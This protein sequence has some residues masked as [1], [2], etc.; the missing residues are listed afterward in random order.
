MNNQTIPLDTLFEKIEL[1]HLRGY[2]YCCL[3]E[4]IYSF[5][6]LNRASEEDSRMPDHGEED[7]AENRFRKSA[8]FDRNVWR[9]LIWRL[10]NEGGDYS[11]IEDEVNNR[12][13]K[14]AKDLG[15][16]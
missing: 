6:L 8:E 9:S 11:N 16:N 15:Q 13:N 12:I 1:D 4:K 10:Q 2:V 14:M 5:Y 7:S 3:I